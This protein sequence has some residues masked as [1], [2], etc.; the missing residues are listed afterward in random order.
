MPF[1]PLIQCNTCQR[2]LGSAPDFSTANFFFY[3]SVLAL[4]PGFGHLANGFAGWW[5]WWWW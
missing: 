4:L 5:W 2:R 3:D 1:A